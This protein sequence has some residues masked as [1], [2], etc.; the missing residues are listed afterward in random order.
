[1]KQME[2]TL[3]FITKMCCHG[4]DKTKEEFRIT[5]LKALMRITFRQLYKCTISNNANKEEDYKNNIKYI[6]DRLFGSTSIKSPMTLKQCYSSKQKNSYKV[7]ICVKDKD[8]DLIAVYK[9]ILIQSSIIGA[10]GAKSRKGYG[11]FIITNIIMKINNNNDKNNNDNTLNI[12]EGLKD[13]NVIEFISNIGLE[14][15]ELIK[16]SIERNSI[17]VEENK[18]VRISFIDLN[19]EKSDTKE[20]EDYPYIKSIKAY[21]IKVKDDYESILTKIKKLTKYR[22][23]PEFY[24][25]IKQE[26]D[27]GNLPIEI[28][29]LGNY[30]LKEWEG[31]KEDKNNK[32]SKKRRFACPIVVSFWKN[33]NDKYMVIKELNY[34]YMLNKMYKG[35]N[36]QENDKDEYEKYILINKAYVNKY[37]EELRKMV[38]RN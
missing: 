10:I 13:K 6:E 12:Y 15:V 35:V 4:A 26:N 33:K 32:F 17:N 37:V 5:E 9:N 23:K 31:Y 1:M 2:V 8:A 22:C 14:T 29:I 36:R 3:E 34:M 38:G 16:A 7:E 24:N 21:K 18:K 19:C 27:S 11:S 28:N 25:P 30:K 20:D